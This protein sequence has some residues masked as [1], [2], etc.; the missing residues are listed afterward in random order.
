MVDEGVQVVRRLP[1]RA[2][3]YAVDSP[4]NFFALALALNVVIFATL[5]AKATAKLE[6]K[7]W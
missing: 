5:W 4:T 3:H 6:A 2:N 1:E 7:T